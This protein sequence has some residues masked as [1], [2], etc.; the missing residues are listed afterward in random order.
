MQ[1]PPR[2]FHPNLRNL[3]IFQARFQ[4]YPMG[5]RPH[6]IHHPERFWVSVAWRISLLLAVALL[7]GTA[8]SLGLLGMTE[9]EAPF[10]NGQSSEQTVVR[11]QSRSNPNLRH[12]QPQSV[13]LVALHRNA[14]N[15]VVR[16]FEGTTRSG[17][18]LPNHLLAPL[19]L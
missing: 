12:H 4:M 6:Q 1:S 8:P 3:F 9:I 18:R 17:H 7:P 19:R 11:A 14:L 2:T 15:L 10:D 5:R 13:L 16:G